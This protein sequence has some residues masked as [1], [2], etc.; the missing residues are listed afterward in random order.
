M[1]L[2][3]ALGQ[4][5]FATQKY[6]LADLD[7][8]GKPTLITTMTCYT[9]YFVS[10]HNDTVAHRWMN[11]Y[12]LDGGG[13]PIAGAANGA[14]ALHGAATLSDYD[15]NERVARDVLTAQ[16]DGRTLG[17]AVQQARVRARLL[18]LDDQVTNWTVLG[19]PT[20]RMD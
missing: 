6:D 13:S 8:S 10:P 14:V 4:V 20:L 2:I 7:N 3:P 5:R 16:L 19:D 1:K 11:G 18:G 9:S 17:E 12:Q 15:H